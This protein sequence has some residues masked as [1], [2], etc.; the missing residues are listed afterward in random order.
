MPSG[1]WDAT[2]QAGARGGRR[3]AVASIGQF[4][5]WPRRHIQREESGAKGGWPADLGGEKILGEFF[6][7]T[8]EVAN[9]LRKEKP[10]R[11]LSVLLLIVMFSLPSLAQEQE[12]Q[13]EPATKLEAFQSRTGAVIVRG[14]S[15][16]GTIRGLG[17]NVTVDA[18]DFRDAR[19]PT[20]RVTGISVSIKQTSRLERE[21][22]SFIDSDEI[23]GLLQGIE[24]IAKASRE[25]TKLENFEAEYR[26]KGDFRVIVFNDSRGQL[27]VA[28]TSGR[29][30]RISAY[31]KLSDLAEFRKLIVAAKSKL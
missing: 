13:V 20:R 30:G 26:T 5:V 8:R 16:V 27:S 3:G 7:I 28:V 18:R 1:R 6:Q 17:G 24:Y 29:V 9:K 23:D 21:N 25:V 15:T 11:Y 22:T 10:M 2:D 31:L 4:P 19:N 12:A 14:Y